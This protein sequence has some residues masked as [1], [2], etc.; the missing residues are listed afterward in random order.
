MRYLSRCFATVALFSCLS[1][2]AATLNDNNIDVRTT[3]YDMSFSDLTFAGAFNLRADRLSFSGSVGDSGTF[4]I[5]GF[6]PGS[7]V[8]VV[9][10]SGMSIT[11]LLPANA[12]GVIFYTAA[13]TGTTDQTLVQS[14]INRGTLTRGITPSGLNFLEFFG[15][16]TGFLRAGGTFDYAI[17]IPGNWSVLGTSTGQVEFLGISSSFSIAQNFV[18]DPTTGRTTFQ[19]LNS[20]Y[21]PTSVGPDIRFVLYGQPVPEPAQLLMFLL[22]LPALALY[23]S[24]SRPR[25]IGASEREA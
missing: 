15:R 10:G 22:G 25:A 5:A 20:S 24:C 18:F 16:N 1:T 14:W 17:S 9:P 21:N 3:T 19:A 8:S 6:P 11:S 12:G 4:G 13:I 7:T 23:R 2:E